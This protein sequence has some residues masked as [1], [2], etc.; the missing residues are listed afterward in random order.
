M[1]KKVKKKIDVLRTR[2]QKLQLQVAGAK[3]QMD[4]PE[5][6]LKLEKELASAEAELNK[7]KDS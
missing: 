4:E 1:D 3:K 6:L 5:E 2:V 7:L